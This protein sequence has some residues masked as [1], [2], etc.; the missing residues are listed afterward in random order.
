VARGVGILR[1]DGGVQALDRL[2]RALLEPLV[3]V[4]QRARALVEL[5]RLPAKRARGAADKQ[6]Q[7]GPEREQ[8]TGD[9]G[10]DQVPPRG[11][12]LLE[13][14]RVG[15][16]LVDPQNP[17]SVVGKDRRV[18]LEQ[19]V[20]AE[21]LLDPVLVARELTDVT[22][23]LA[24]LDRLVEVAVH[25][26]ALADAGLGAVRPGEHP[27]GPPDLDGDER[28]VAPHFA[29]E[30]RGGVAADL[31]LAAADEGAAKH[32]V[33][34]LGDARPAVGECLIRER[35]RQ[36]R[37]QE[38]AADGDDRG[39]CDQEMRSSVS[40]RSVAALR[41]EPVPGRSRTGLDDPYRIAAGNP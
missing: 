9:R 29:V 5:A 26:E 27:V 36:D 22:D 28:A 8:H 34:V 15:V 13:P 17:A 12:R 33:D 4:H 10:P 40:E 19:V 20:V 35:P 37:A 14:L 32:A 2:E 21:T 7:R 6:R 31:H 41:L 24:A 30:A 23:G 1:L 38:D 25:V 18:H 3:G 16:D 39:A 11:E